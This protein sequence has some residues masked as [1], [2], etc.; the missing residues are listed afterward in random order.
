MKRSPLKRSVKPLKRSKLRVAGVSDVSEI[1]R[2]IQSIIRA[3]AIHRD[4]GCVLRHYPETGKCGGYRKDGELILQFDHL[5][6]RAYAVSYAD[7]RLGVILCFRHHFYW[8]KQHPN[9][10]ITIIRK[11]IGKERSAL[12][13]RVQADRTPHKVDWN[14][15]LLALK[16]ELKKY[17]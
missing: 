5:N 14:L 3:I 7:V 16:Q 2:E 15:E 9:E 6:S 17:S 12:L 8:K 4:G 10:F 13:D 1:K 11:Q